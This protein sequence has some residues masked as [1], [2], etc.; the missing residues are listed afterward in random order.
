MSLATH[1]RILQTM[2]DV[3]LWAGTSP[4]LTALTLATLPLVLIAFRVYR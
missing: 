4:L 2:N 3:R 1:S